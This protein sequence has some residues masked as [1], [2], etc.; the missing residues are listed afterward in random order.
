[1]ITQALKDATDEF[2]R[3]VVHTRDALEV[4]WRRSGLG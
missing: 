4:F 1:M 3:E 2:L